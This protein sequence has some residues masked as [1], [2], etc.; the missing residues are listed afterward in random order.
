MTG[1]PVPSLRSLGEREIEYVGVCLR[2]MK[3]KKLEGF[4]STLSRIIVFIVNAS[5]NLFSMTMKSNIA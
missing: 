3:R 2:D 4:H 1:N 5:K